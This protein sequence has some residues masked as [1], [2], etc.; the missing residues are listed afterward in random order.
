[1]LTWVSDKVATY[2]KRGWGWRVYAVV[3]VGVALVL[4]G[5]VLWWKRR[6]QAAREHEAFVAQ[7]DARAAAEDAR[8]DADEAQVEVLKRRA[9]AAAMRAD[10]AAAEAVSAQQKH[11]QDLAS[12]DR[13]R[14]WRDVP[15][16]PR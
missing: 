3:L 1:M 12:V 16:G 6:Q 11:D 8:A 4:A 2:R 13:I 7:V 14:S 9:A 10:L 15:D 5:V